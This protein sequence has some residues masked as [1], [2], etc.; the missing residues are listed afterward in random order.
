ML[1]KDT[2]SKEHAGFVGAQ[3]DVAF[4]KVLRVLVSGDNSAFKEQCDVDRT[5][6]FFVSRKQYP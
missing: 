1:F 5:F 3:L 6:T 4:R 2:C